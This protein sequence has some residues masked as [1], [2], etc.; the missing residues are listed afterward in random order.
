MERIKKHKYT[1]AILIILLVAAFLRLHN[2]DKYMTFLGDEGRDA[3]VV[4]D[5]ITG[6]DDI[7]QGDFHA[8]A[9]HLTLL[10]PTASVG[11]FYLGPI[12]Y[13]FMAPFMWLFGGHPAGAAVMVALFGIATVWLIYKVTA[14]FFNRKAGIIAALLYS[15]APIIII[16]SRA[17]WNPNLMPFF[18]L[19]FLYTLYKGVQTN[20]RFLFF[21]A[22]ILF[23][24]LLQLHYLALFVATI[25]GLYLTII[26]L[27]YKKGDFLKKGETYIVQIALTFAGFFLGFLPFFG[28]EL[29]HDFANTQNIFR[30]IFQS[31]ETGARSNIGETLGLVFFKLFGRILA[32][33]PSPTVKEEMYSQPWMVLWIIGIIVLAVAISLFVLKKTIAAYKRK[34]NT[35]FQW[36]LL[37][38]WLFVGVMFFGFYRKEIYDYYLAFLFPLPFILTG[39]F[40]GTYLAKA[41]TQKSNGQKAVCTNH[42]GSII[43]T[44]GI[45]IVLVVLVW[46]NLRTMPLMYTPNDQY[47]QAEGIAHFVLDKADGKPFN[48]ALI[49]GGNSDHAY[50]FFFRKAGKEPIAIENPE[51]D[52]QR[53]TVTDQL[54]VIC[55]TLPCSPLGHSLW[56]VAGFG[57]ADIV[58]MWDLGVVHV[59]KL[60]PYQGQESD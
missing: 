51:A 60:E 15:I 27:F 39:G 19:A 32:N 8:A 59:Y 16:Y 42:F 4:Q 34:D 40:L 26:Q 3:I 33:F 37:A 12:Y 57:R 25:G 11:G 54:L 18:S 38:L 13:Y 21:L 49:T 24:I 31:G 17:S 7:L 1:V 50:R 5:I 22:G 10:G 52:P 23:G 58:G 20:K 30:F 44:V 9:E 14:E 2:I 47:G 56:E 6:F 29:R 28:F 35:F 41:F 48:F 55:D 53:E 45:S 46:I 43:T 36:G